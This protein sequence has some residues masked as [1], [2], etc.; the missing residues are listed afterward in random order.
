VALV[1]AIKKEVFFVQSA[2]LVG[3][4]VIAI[5]SN[6]YLSIQIFQLGPKV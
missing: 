5:T 2:K 1:G 4:D 6:L 3:W